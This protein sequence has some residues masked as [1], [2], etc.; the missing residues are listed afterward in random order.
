MAKVSPVT[1]RLRSAD[2][3]QTY[4]SQTVDHLAVYLPVLIVVLA[5][6]NVTRIVLYSVND[7][8]TAELGWSVPL[9]VLALCLRCMLWLGKLKLIAIVCAE[10]MLYVTCGEW[11][12]SFGDF[13]CFEVR[14]IV[15]TLGV[16]NVYVGMF[17]LC[18]E[19]LL[20]LSGLILGT[21]Y[22]ILRTNLAFNEQDIPAM[23][24]TGALPALIVYLHL[25]TVKSTFAELC[26]AQAESALWKQLVNSLP[27]SLAL[28]DTSTTLYSNPSAGE[29]LHLQDPKVVISTLDP[30][31]VEKQHKAGVPRPPIRERH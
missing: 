8:E 20:Y 14:A 12:V 23:V 2:L 17:L 10:A 29:F 9:L 24:L 7:E 15:V 27:T 30:L 1:L 26:Q 25:R 22:L 6:M 19:W 3:E 21:V 4:R 16:I 11:I 5:A 28:L 13:F 18:W 31:L